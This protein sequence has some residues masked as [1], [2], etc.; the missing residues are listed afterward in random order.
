MLLTLEPDER[1]RGAMTAEVTARGCDTTVTAP[2]CPERV[3]TGELKSKA[4]R[5]LYSF[6]SCV[7][8]VPLAVIKQITYLLFIRRLDD[9]HTLAENKASTTKQ[10]LQDSCFLLG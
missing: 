6:S 2:R 5:V 8:S 1:H 7:V 10:P 4:D 9:R 3:I